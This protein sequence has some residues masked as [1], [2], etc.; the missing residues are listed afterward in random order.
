MDLLVWGVSG[1][2]DREEGAW[3]RGGIGGA[4]LAFELY[5]LFILGRVR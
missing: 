3:G 4:Y 5:L 2:L 1:R